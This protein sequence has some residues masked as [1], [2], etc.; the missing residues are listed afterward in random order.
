V[1]A[2]RSAVPLEATQAA[3]IVDRIVDILRDSIRDT[4]AWARRKKPVV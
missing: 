3:E 2:S 1:E 4:V